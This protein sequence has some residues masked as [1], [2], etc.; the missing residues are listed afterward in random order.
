NNGR[1]FRELAVAMA[2]AIALSAFVALSLTPMMC[3]LLV[4]PT[5]A[6][7]GWGAWLHRQL[8]RLAQAYRSLLE[9]TVGRPVLFIVV[10]LGAFAVTALMFSTAPRELAPPEDRGAFFVMVAGPEGAGFD[11]T[12]ANLHEIEQRLLAMRDRG[13]PIYRVITR[14]SEEHM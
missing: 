3:R 12:I 1:L 13:E 8:G 6:P 7:R 9:R 5:P 14:R 2:G 10:M 4:R 11:Y